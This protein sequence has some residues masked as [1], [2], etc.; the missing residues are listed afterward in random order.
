MISSDY[1]QISFLYSQTIII[2]WKLSQNIITPTNDRNNT[3][4]VKS[5]W[6]VIYKHWNILTMFVFYIKY[7]LMT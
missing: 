2:W 6:S 5:L 3:N 7:E 1:E 4:L